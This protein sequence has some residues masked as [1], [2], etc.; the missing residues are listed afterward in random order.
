[1][2]CPK[3]GY[4]SFEYYDICKKCSSDLAGYKQTHSI[5]SLV[6][7][8]EVEEKLAAESRLLE[9]E[10]EQ[11][12]EAP[13][14]HD[15]MFSFDLPDETPSAPAPVAFDPFNF[16]EPSPAQT[17]GSKPENDVL[18][19][20]RDLLAP[21]EGSPFA[22]APPVPPSAPAAANSAPYTTQPGEFDLDNFSWD[23]APAA[24][25]APAKKEAADDFDSLFGSSKETGS[26]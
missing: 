23:G 17:S 7:P 16:D 8:P 20:F 1:M 25:A 10:T 2:K 13:E 9:S 18:G 12:S 24:A 3:C 6:L 21:A 4:N 26:K 15:D 22:A 5:T 19:G 11:Q 14:T